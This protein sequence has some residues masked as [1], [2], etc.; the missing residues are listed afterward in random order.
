MNRNTPKSTAFQLFAKAVVVVA[1]L[2]VW[3]GAATTT[4]Q[5]GMVFADWPLSLGSFNPPGWL[6]NMIPFLEHSHRLLAKLVGILVLV[7]FSWSYVKSGRRALE[8]VGL[9]VLLAVILGFFI[10]AGSERLD[11]GEKKKWL[12]IALGLSILPLSWIVWSWR[13]RGW[14]LLE[15]LTALALLMVMTQAI[16]GGLRVTEISNGFAVIHGCFAQAFFCV[17]ILIVMVSGKGWSDLGFVSTPSR[18]RFLKYAGVAL[19]VLV[20]MQ[21]IFGASMRH[22]HRSS[23]PDEGLLLTQGRWIP[24]F[25]DPMIAVLFLHKLTAF[26]ILFFVLG[27]IL[28]LA[29]RPSLF[30]PRARRSLLFVFALLLLQIVLGLSVIG[31]GKSFWITNVHVLNGLAILAI[32]FVFSVKAVRGRSSEG[33]LAKIGR[34]G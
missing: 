1:I 27:L 9:V 2:L 20:L 8:V 34:R 23:L 10:A 13:A 21:L 14:S 6:E 26:C 25:D 3:W 28:H 22:F 31:T 33:A 19:V 18:V 29:G 12:S 5:A 16:F 11:A 7:L 4:K 24:S 15:K 30:D 17:L 32:S